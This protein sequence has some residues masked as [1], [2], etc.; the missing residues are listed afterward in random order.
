MAERRIGSTEPRWPGLFHDA[1]APFRCNNSS[2]V[3]AFLIPVGAHKK[4]DIAPGAENQ[5]SLRQVT[6][7]GQLSPR[8][9]WA[10]LWLQ[11]SSSRNVDSFA[12][13][14]SASVQDWTEVLD[15]WKLHSPRFLWRHSIGKQP[16]LPHQCPKSASPNLQVL[17]NHRPRLC[18]SVH[19]PNGFSR[20]P[21]AW[22]SSPFFAWLF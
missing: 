6:G 9:Q 11:H 22:W 17:G 14:S 16:T 20:D 1:W 3:T 2:P 8:C 19:Q 15:T 10:F 4:L 12:I 5:T 13:F 18:Y 7:R 21:G